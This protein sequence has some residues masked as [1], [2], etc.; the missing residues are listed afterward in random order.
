MATAETTIY[1]TSIS[2]ESFVNKTGL[3][4]FFTGLKEVFAAKS[5]THDD[6]TSGSAGFM[7]AIQVSSLTRLSTSADKNVMLSFSARL[8]AADWSSS[9][10][11]SQ[12]VTVPGM[13]A[14]YNY[15]PMFIAP[16][17]T[18]STDEVAAEALACISYATTAAGS[19]T[20]YCYTEK[21]TAD[22]TVMAQRIL[23]NFRDE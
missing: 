8:L 22:I 16:S 2:S 4:R 1:P 19:V 5:H 13:R 7:T 10:P 15:G 11:Y 20:F 12:T 9:A 18:Q 23:D 14:Y 17:G 21:P 6:A 3:Q